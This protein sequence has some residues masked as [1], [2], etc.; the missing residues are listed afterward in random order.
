[1]FLAG[2]ASHAIAGDYPFA[3]EWEPA[4]DW[5]TIVVHAGADPAKAPPGGFKFV[6]RSTRQA[7][8]VEVHVYCT[9]EAH[10]SQMREQASV[11]QVPKPLDAS[12]EA[13][14]QWWW[15]VMHET[16]EPGPVH[17]PKP[18]PPRRPYDDETPTAGK[19]LIGVVANPCGDVR[20]VWLQQSSGN[21]QFDLSTMRTVRSWRIKQGPERGL[22][23]IEYFFE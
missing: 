6:D 19:A 20:D 2:I 17:M 1:M 14:Q 18:L 16:C 7:Y 9:D 15:I 22:F 3:P 5:R 10:C 21:R 11:V 12:K 23:P 13:V 8:A 4:K